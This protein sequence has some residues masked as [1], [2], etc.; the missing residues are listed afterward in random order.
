M[1]SSGWLCTVVGSR[2]VRQTEMTLI[3]SIDVFED[4][5][6][7]NGCYIFILYYIPNLSSRRSFFLL[8]VNVLRNQAEDSSKGSLQGGLSQ[9][10]LCTHNITLSILGSS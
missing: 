3:G 2:S 7:Q 4:Q 8:K 10:S 9:L 1:C 6:N 5:A